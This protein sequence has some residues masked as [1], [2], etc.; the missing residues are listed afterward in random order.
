MYI[1]RRKGEF[2]VPYPAG[3]WG[4]LDKFANMLLDQS[5]DLEEYDV[6][7]FESMDKSTCIGTLF[8]VIGE[9]EK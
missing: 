2:S 7:N 6:W 5:A 3:D 8:D 1:I 9:E 4:E